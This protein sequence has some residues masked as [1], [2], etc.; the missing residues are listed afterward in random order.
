MTESYAKRA[1]SATNF[2]PERQFDAD[3]EKEAMPK[4]MLRAWC[5]ANWDRLPEVVRNDCIAHLKAKIPEEVLQRW[6]E[7]DYEEEFMFHFRAGMRIRNILREQLT[8]DK[9][10]EAATNYE[11]KPYGSRNWDDYYTG[12]LDEL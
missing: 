9:L 1:D 8:D 6:K 5:R 3:R 11:G 10:P 4:D 2:D 12:A 7:K